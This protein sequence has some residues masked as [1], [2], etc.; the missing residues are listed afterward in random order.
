MRTR[1]V[2][3]FL[4]IDDDLLEAR[5]YICHDYYNISHDHNL[6]I[7]KAY[8]QHNNQQGSYLDRIHPVLDRIV[9]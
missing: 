8:V 2:D 3:R 1:N 7:N 5:I 6:I 4:G 9:R